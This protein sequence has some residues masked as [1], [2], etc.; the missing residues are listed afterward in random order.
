MS[1]RGRDE[2]LRLEVE[3]LT[4][5]N[6]RLQ[7]AFDTAVAANRALSRRAG[8]AEHYRMAL[9]KIRMIAETPASSGRGTVLLIARTALGDG[10]EA[11]R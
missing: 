9:E 8:D 4:A 2:A 10:Q 3:R 5:E 11:A 7:R 6:T 1:E